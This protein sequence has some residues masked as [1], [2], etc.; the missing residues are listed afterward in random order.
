[1][2]PSNYQEWKNCI[3]QDCKIVLSNSF[4]EQRLLILK[5]PNHQETLKFKELYGEN[6]LINI[7]TWYETALHELG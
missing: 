1:M 7:I 5:N 4:I 6:Q 3:T 2:I